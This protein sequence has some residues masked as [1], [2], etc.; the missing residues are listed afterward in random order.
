[1]IFLKQIVNSVGRFLVVAVVATIILTL[2]AS[3]LLPSLRSF[4]SDA[5]IAETNYVEKGN[6]P[7]APTLT[8]SSEKISLTV[9]ETVDL[10]SNITAKSS[11]GED[12]MVQLTEDYAKSVEERD[13][14]FVYKVNGD[15][16]HTL[17]S[18]IDASRS[19]NWVVFYLIKDGKEN[20]LLKVPYTVGL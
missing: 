15:E 19:G 17:V 3:V 7:S 1:M 4:F 2:I 5:F 6:R 14:V 8:C 9:G 16:S 12:L 13:Q 18:E 11:S 20:A 10:F